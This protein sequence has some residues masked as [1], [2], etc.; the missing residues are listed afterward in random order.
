M[1]V[2]DRDVCFAHHPRGCGVVV[3]FIAVHAASGALGHGRGG[4]PHEFR[5][6]GLKLGHE[7]AQVILVVLDDRDLRTGGVE[8]A[9]LPVLEVMKSPV[10][11]DR[12]PFRVSEPLLELLRPV[13]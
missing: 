13:L 12:V 1:Q 6:G 8:F 11:M 5:A 4:R 3:H 7:C 9:V 2:V 10:E